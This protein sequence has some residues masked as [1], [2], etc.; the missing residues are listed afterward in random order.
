MKN[1]END[2]LRIAQII[3]NAKTGGVISCVM[4]FFRNIDRDKFA[5]DFYMYAPSPYDD[6]IKALGGRIF[7]FPNVLKFFRSVSALKKF[8]QAENYYAVHAHLTTLAFVPLFAAKLAGVKYRVCHAHSTG[9][10]S[11]SV[12]IVKQTLK[13]FSR[14]F[15]THI[16]G[17]SLLSNNYLYGKKYGEKAFLLHNAI[18]TDKFRFDEIKTKR[19]KAEKNIENKKII[20]T[21]GRFEFQKNLPFL[22][23]AFSMVKLE[24]PNTHLFLVGGGSEIDKIEGKI[25]E[26]KLEND[27]DV[28]PNNNRV[29]D[30]Y[31]LFDI[32][33]LPSRFEGLPLVAVEAQAMGIPCLLSDEI[34]R[35]ADIS[36]K[37]RFISIDTPGKWADEIIKA[38][39][40]TQ[41]ENLLSADASDELKNKIEKS[42][43]DIKS[44]TKRLEKF[45][46][47]LEDINYKN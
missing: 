24:M 14:I 30:Y 37:C 40:E 16:A 46:L 15:P 39:N 17:C 42:G 7:Y 25:A 11:E 35:E 47:S 36:G 31:A 43:Y 32:F 38:L 20:G 33:V 5:F 44:E 21:V 28:V 19:L 26:Y 12:W 27:V 34:T 18:N 22:I 8:F 1:N 2:K 13:H 3:G 45:Y 10:K 6:E 9:H 29:E 23:D 4:N 41:N